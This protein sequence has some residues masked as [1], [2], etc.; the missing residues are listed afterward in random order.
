MN[1]E[2]NIYLDGILGVVVGDALGV[3]V[4]FM[5]REELEQSPVNGMI[6][7]G[8]FDLPAGSWSDDSSLTLATLDSLR[9][10]YDLT[11]MIH[12]FAEWMTE[13]SY[14]P[15][16]EAFDVG[17][18]TRDAIVRYLK[19]HDVSTCGGTTEYDNGNGSLMRILPICLYCYEE[20]KKG[21]ISDKEAIQM[22]HEVSALT[23]NHIRSQ[24]A[25]GLYFFLAK[26][27]LEKSGSLSQR[28]Q[29]GINKGLAFYQENDFDMSELQKFH[30]LTNLETF[31]KTSR[32][33]IQSY[34]Y[35]V[36]SL[37]AAL[38]CLLNSEDYKEC[39][40][41]AVNLGEDTDTIAA[42]AGGLA[43][44]FYGIMSIPKEWM[45]VIQ[46]RSWIEELCRNRW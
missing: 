10:G 23:H 37:E 35:V 25:C 19:D 42:I 36:V 1:I 15:F 46:R 6:G 43:G 21:K 28:L 34:G 38:W 32:K 45:E 30:R 9:Q 31:Q 29:L 24:M 18:G 12:K 40:L 2:R 3:P 7:Y 5:E 20:Q 4:E 22:I 26:A 16:G 14:S 41:L 33:E 27:I 13:G 44:L 39:E 11:D 17:I 8:T